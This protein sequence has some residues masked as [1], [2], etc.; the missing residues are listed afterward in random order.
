M[1][2][3]QTIKDQMETAQKIIALMKSAPKK[4]TPTPMKTVPK[5]TI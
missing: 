3:A 4:I 5:N 1:E 2:T